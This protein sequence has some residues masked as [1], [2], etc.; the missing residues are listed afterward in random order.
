[1]NREEIL[2]QLQEE[3]RKLGNR[4]IQIPA[5]REKLMSA[6]VHIPSFFETMVDTLP[7]EPS[8]KSKKE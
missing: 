3:K 5:N 7:E 8:E 1:M 4:G 2:K 6:G